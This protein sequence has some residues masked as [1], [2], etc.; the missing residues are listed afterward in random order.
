MPKIK[1]MFKLHTVD[2]MK[3]EFKIS[4]KLKLRCYNSLSLN[5]V[6]LFISTKTKTKTVH[7]NNG[8]I[9]LESIT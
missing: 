6:K 1:V 3:V 7:T 9:Y 4:K 8:Q 5:P 2:L